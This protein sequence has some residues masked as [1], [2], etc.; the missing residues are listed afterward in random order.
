MPT[1]ADLQAERERLRAANARTDF[2]TAYA[3]TAGGAEVLAAGMAVLRIILDA[4]D[5][6]AARFVSDL[7]GERDETRAH[8]LM[9]ESAHGWLSAVGEQ[10]AIA[11]AKIPEI[12]AAFRRGIKPRDL[13][14][15]S[16][17]ADR[18]RELRSGTNAPGPWRTAL[19]P[20][21]ADIMDALSEH[22][23]VRQVTFVKSSGVGGTEAMYNWIGYAMQ[24]L[25]NKDTAR[26]QLAA[27]GTMADALRD[28]ISGQPIPWKTMD[29]SW[30]PLTVQLAFDIVNAG[31]AAELA[32]HAAAERHRAAMEAAADP[33]AYD[34]S[35]G[36]PPAFVREVL[37]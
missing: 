7:A 21:L 9:S 10:A 33:A 5:A 16:E 8:Y 15:V 25:G 34:F 26:D 35:T 12:G 20:Y 30:Q 17:W 4:L 32:H 6:L 18:H 2:E 1:I 3:A 13:L 14:T 19:T 24:H 36:W 29:G 31:K 28:P 37:P 11:A 23:S 22:S 27:G